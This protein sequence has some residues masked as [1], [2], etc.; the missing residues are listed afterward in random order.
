MHSN[1]TGDNKTNYRVLFRGGD[2]ALGLNCAPVFR[3]GSRGEWGVTCTPLLPLVICYSVAAVAS[4]L[5]SPVA[6]Q[7]LREVWD[8][9]Y[10][11]RPAH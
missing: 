3:V 2:N 9:G 5:G 1:A 7:M 10:T 4:L 11:S 6:I 8:Q